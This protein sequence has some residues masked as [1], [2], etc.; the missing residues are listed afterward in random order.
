MLRKVRDYSKRFRARV[1]LRYSKD[2]ARGRC[3]PHDSKKGKAPSGSTKMQLAT[4]G[5][6]LAKMVAKIVAVAR[7]L[8]GQRAVCF[9]GA[10]DGQ[11]S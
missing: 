5:S 2:T 9:Y 7:L 6:E 1:T 10:T 8:S 3:E 11:G 4:T